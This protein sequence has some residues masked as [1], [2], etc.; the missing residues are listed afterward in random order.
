MRIRILAVAAIA[1]LV[2]M[3]GGCSK[4]KTG[5]LVGVSFS[6]P[7][8]SLATG[9]MNQMKYLGTVTLK[10]EDGKRLDAVCDARLLEKLRGGQRLEIE[11]FEDTVTKK[12]GWKVIRALD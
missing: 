11:P 7:M 10:M 6:A 1:A 9:Q 8:D 5:T 2:L 12:T 4:K 3:A